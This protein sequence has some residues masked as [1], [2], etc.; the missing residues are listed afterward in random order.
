MTQGPKGLPRPHYW[1]GGEQEGAQERDPGGQDAGHP[2][3][4]VAP[5]PAPLVAP[6]PAGLVAPPP[7]RRTR[8]ARLHRCREL[9][10]G[11]V[12]GAVAP[13]LVGPWGSLST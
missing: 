4:L 5:H 12:D 8:M 6:H 3:G 13:K 9:G 11:H 2:A 10:R 7:G 1:V